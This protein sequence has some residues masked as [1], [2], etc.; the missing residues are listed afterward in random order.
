MSPTWRFF[1]RRPLQVAFSVL[2]LVCIVQILWWLIDQARYTRAVRD[3]LAS[4]AARDLDAAQRLHAKGTPTDRLEALY[5][6]LALE[7]TSDGL[8][9]TANIE[10]VLHAERRRHMW[11]YGWEGAFFILV[12]AAG[13]WIIGLVLRQRR[14]LVERQSNFLAAVTHELKNPLAS[15]KL[16]AETLDLREVNATGRKALSARMLDDVGRLEA[17]VTKLLDVAR[18]DAQ[19]ARNRANAAIQPVPLGPLVQALI[20]EDAFRARVHGVT[21]ALVADD[22]AAARAVPS[23]ARL[24]VSNLLDNAVKSVSAAS[25][26]HVQARVTQEGKWARLDIKDEGVGFSEEERAHL[27]TRFYR[28]G[29]EDRRR[30]QGTGLGLYLVRQLVEGG[31]GRVHA[32]STGPGQGAQFTVWWPLALAE[33]KA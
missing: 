17:M 7:E 15:L 30:T 8:A 13:M 24:V 9:A 25:R 14:Q 4:A 16:A 6:H 28:T 19:G 33:G 27:F 23:H 12:L 11:R 5:P 31:R 29:S 10:T 20:D 21:P 3:R 26:A 18:L 2:L 22:G 1:R 32:T